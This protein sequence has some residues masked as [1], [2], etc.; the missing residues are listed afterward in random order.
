MLFKRKIILFL[1][2][3]KGIITTGRLWV[4]EED[5]DFQ[6]NS[7]SAVNKSRWEQRMNVTGDRPTLW[8]QLVK[9]WRIM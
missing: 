7:K 9:F 8:E 5:S 2:S 3:E 1:G 4:M 6:E